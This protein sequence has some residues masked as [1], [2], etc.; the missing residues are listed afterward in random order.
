MFMY[1]EKVNKYL[2]QMQLQINVS[3]KQGFFFCGYIKGT[4]FEK[5][6]SWSYLYMKGKGWVQ[7]FSCGTLVQILLSTPH[8]RILVNL[9]VP[10]IITILI[11]LRC[12][13]QTMRLNIGSPQPVP[14]QSWPGYHHQIHGFEVCIC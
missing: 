9:Y 3:S 13:T 6:I 4:P 8:S 10:H 2:E 5:V 14:Q 11:S 12:Y 7:P 1:L